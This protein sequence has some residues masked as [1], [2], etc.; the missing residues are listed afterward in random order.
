MNKIS[1]KLEKLAKIVIFISKD[2]TWSEKLEAYNKALDIIVYIKNSKQIEDKEWIILRKLTDELIKDNSKPINIKS[3]KINH[4]DDLKVKI[5]N[6]MK[7]VPYI[8]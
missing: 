2:I 8:K 6:E 4:I 3:Y 1:Q 7:T 5:I